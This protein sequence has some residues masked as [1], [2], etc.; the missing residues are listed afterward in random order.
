VLGDDRE[1]TSG[2][3]PTMILTGRLGKSCAC[4]RVGVDHAAVAAIT[5]DA[6]TH[7]TRRTLPFMPFL[8]YSA[9]LQQSYGPLTGKETHA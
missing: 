9:S 8:R 3:G 1:N 6:A 5:A 4:A 2:L 7:P